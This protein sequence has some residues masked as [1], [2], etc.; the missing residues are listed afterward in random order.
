MQIKILG[1]YGKESKDLEK[2]LFKIL[3]SLNACASITIHDDI[4]ML[5]NYNLT[6]TPAIQIQNEIIDNKYIHNEKYIVEKIKIH[7]QFDDKNQE[8][9]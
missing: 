6:K 5:L 2:M 4:D 7:L 1:I 9:A 3:K 8:T